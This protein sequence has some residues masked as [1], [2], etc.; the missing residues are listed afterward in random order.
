MKKILSLL[1]TITL[2]STSTTNLVA[3]NTPQEYTP[4]ELA[5]LKEKNKINTKNQTIRDNLEWIAPQERPFNNIDNKYYY[6]VWRG[7]KNN[8]WRI[9]KFLNDTNNEKKIDNY[10]KYSLIFKPPR[11]RYYTLLIKD[12]II[13]T[14]NTLYADDGSYFKSVYCWNLAD[15]GP[16]LIVDD[17]G[18]VKVNGE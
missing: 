4:E 3:C 18:N 6:V 5:K 13:N 14:N 10:V 11:F 16:D 17:K 12:G 9:I 7:N 15:T 8:T 2:I 1:G